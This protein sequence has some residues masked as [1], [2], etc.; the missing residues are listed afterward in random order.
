MD[1]SI[2]LKLSFL[3]HVTFRAF[4]IVQRTKVRE[5]L[6]DTA[7]SDALLKGYK[8][9]PEQFASQYS[10]LRELLLSQTDICYTV[11]T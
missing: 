10:D 7:A 2:P 9:R 11:V 6:V 3:F 1:T 4:I 5:D 8:W